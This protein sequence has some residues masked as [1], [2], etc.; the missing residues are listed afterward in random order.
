MVYMCLQENY[1]LLIK[2][3]IKNWFKDLSHA[4]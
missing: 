1:L 4:Y 3:N 2:G